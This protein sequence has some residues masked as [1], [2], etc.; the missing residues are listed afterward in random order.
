MKI[1]GDEEKLWVQTDR[2]GYIRQLIDSR[3]SSR[4]EGCGTAG[5]LWLE[6][7][8]MTVDTKVTG[9]AYGQLETVLAPG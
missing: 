4:G 7:L 9:A 1:K 2:A 3:G 6:I 5:K 8:L